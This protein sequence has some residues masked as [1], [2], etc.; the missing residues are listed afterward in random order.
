M[1]SGTHEYI[2]DSRNDTIL[3]YIN[4]D[5]ISRS[6]AK[7]SV[8]DSG[9]LLGDGVWEGIRLHNGQLVFLT[10]HMDRLYAG[11]NAIGMDIGMSSEELTNKIM[12][13]IEANQM[14]SDVHLR[15]IVSRGL[16][17][18][19]YQHPRV[20]IGGPTIVIIPEY[21]IVTED[22]KEK[23]LELVSVNTIR[24]SN[25]TQDPKINSLSKFNC[26]QA[27]IEADRLGADEGL[28][29][30]KNGYVS[31]CNSTNFFIVQKSEVWTSTGEYCLNGVTR[32][33]IIN[34]CNSNNIQVHEKNFIMDD[35]Y[36]ADEAFVT[37]TFAGV[38]PVTKIDEYILSNGKKGSTTD[39]LQ[40]LYSMEINNLYPKK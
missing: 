5:I 22:S 18:T 35:V 1:P 34:L 2:Q 29:L 21:K 15:L 37:G 40:N 26:I 33:A 30:D 24:S 14:Y 20:N 16:K 31:T 19:P 10:E 7:V 11:A 12:E 27:C 4:G 25:L 8:F 13:T 36:A 17:S 38:L 9:F 28:M 32:G 3:I 23:G 39:R 6:D